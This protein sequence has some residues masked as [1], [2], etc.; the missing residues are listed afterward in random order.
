MSS[1]YRFILVSLVDRE[2]GL[3]DCRSVVPSHITVPSR[4]EYGKIRGIRYESSDSRSI[5][6]ESTGGRTIR[7][8]HSTMFGGLTETW[9]ITD[10]M[11]EEDVKNLSET[12]K[13]CS[14]QCKERVF[15]GQSN[16]EAFHK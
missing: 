5:V 1:T 9:S 6:A 3:I 14:Y 15:E 11:I 16:L 12:R 13:N 2:C 7:L 4:K 10:L 8:H